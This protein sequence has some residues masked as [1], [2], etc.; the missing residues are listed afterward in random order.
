MFEFEE[1]KKAELIH[2]LKMGED[3]GF[4]ENFDRD[5][6]LKKLHKTRISE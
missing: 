1:A 6:F 3:S 2:E 5:D 4:V